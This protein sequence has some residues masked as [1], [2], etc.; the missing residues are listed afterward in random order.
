MVRSNYTLY[1]LQ[2]SWKLTWWPS[3]WTTV[4]RQQL[5][6]VPRRVGSQLVVW[7]GSPFQFFNHFSMTEKRMFEMEQHWPKKTVPPRIWD[8]LPHEW[9]AA[10]GIWGMVRCLTTTARMSN[11]DLVFQA[12]NA[13]ISDILR[14]VFLLLQLVIVTVNEYFFRNVSLLSHHTIPFCETQPKSKKKMGRETGWVASR[15]SKCALIPPK[16]QFWHTPSTFGAL[17]VHWRG[18]I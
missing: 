12:F 15:A 14:R 10:A 5:R 1:A 18:T 3:Y 4:W 9:W 16:V 8:L 17:W 13:R 6:N 11:S 7:G 2:N